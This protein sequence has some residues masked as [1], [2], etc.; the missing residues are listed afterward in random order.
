MELSYKQIRGRLLKAHSSRN[1]STLAEENF[2]NTH[3][4]TTRKIS[5]NELPADK[6]F[7]DRWN[8]IR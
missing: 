4:W 8:E 3:L 7:L 1:K 5:G 2:K 6:P